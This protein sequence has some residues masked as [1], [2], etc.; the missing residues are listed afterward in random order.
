MIGG[1]REEGRKR[2]GVNK[3]GQQQ[4]KQRRREAMW[5]GVT[6]AR[7][8]ERKDRSA[9]HV[10]GR[11]ELTEPAASRSAIK[12]RAIILIF[13]FLVPWFPRDVG[14]VRLRSEWGGTCEMVRVLGAIEMLGKGWRS[15][16]E[17][18]DEVVF[19]ADDEQRAE[20]RSAP[21]RTAGARRT[22]LPWPLICV[23]APCITRAGCCNRYIVLTR[24]I[25]NRGR[26]R[27]AA[28]TRAGAESRGKTHTP[29][30]AFS[31]FC[32]CFTVAPL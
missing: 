25:K 28:G 6:R 8:I 2:E 3:N 15:G 14:L 1:G 11:I 24:R 26:P 27:T 7:P 19:T 10:R 20:R 30:S 29:L 16:G 21:L 9:I 13:S 17:L 22:R 31:S 32:P 4:E 12:V 23:P 18:H 5:R